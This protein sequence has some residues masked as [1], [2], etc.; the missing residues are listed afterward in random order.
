MILVKSKKNLTA[1]V[2]RRLK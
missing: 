1:L 2:A